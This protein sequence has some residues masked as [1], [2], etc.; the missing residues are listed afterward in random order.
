MAWFCLC[1]HADVKARCTLRNV[2]ITNPFWTY[3]CDFI[4]SKHPKSRNKAKRPKGWITVSGLYEGYVRVPWDG[5]TE[6]RVSVPAMCSICGREGDEVSRLIT[7]EKFLASE[8]VGIT[9]N[10]GYPF[11]TTH[12]SDPTILT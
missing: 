3:C 1:V 10:G 9:S 12:R 8:Q 5:T 7:M 11:T 4:S 2:K 6:P